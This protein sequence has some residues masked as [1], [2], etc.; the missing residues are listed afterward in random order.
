MK[1][2]SDVFRKYFGEDLFPGSLNVDILSHSTLQHDLDANNYER[3]FVVPRAEFRGGPDY[4]GDAQVWRCILK[5]HK[6][7]AP[8]SCWIFRRIGSKVHPGE[9]EIV[10]S[11]ALVERYCLKHADS[12]TLTLFEGSG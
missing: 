6:I 4:L 7:S 8:I 2:N 5:C 9:I 12:V 11:I 10:A 1:E 3:A